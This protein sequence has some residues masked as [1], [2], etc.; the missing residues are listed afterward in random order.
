MDRR[1]KQ[2]IRTIMRRLADRLSE[3][4]LAR[5]VNL[6]PAR[7]RQLFK[8][9]TGLSPMQYVKRLRMKRSAILLRTS[10]LSIKEVSFQSG[11]SDV[12]HFVRE[13][14]KYYDL[15]PTEFRAECNRLPRKKRVSTLMNSE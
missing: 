3:Q 11:A 7:L 10:F 1:V 5:S 14:K 4:A 2:I 13:F 8:K 15:T 12:S 6:S 9:E